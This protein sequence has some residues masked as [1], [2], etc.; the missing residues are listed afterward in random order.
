MLPESRQGSS[1]V[2]FRPPSPR[3]FR[4]AFRSLFNRS[5]G[6]PKFTT[7][8]HS[9]PLSPTSRH[10]SNRTFRLVKKKMHGASRDFCGKVSRLRGQLVGTTTGGVSWKGIVEGL[11]S[12][13]LSRLYSM[14]LIS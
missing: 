7:A 9:L 13:S 5:L 1:A 12:D 8:L 10:D 14:P 11:M 3:I 2:P 4:A 6:A